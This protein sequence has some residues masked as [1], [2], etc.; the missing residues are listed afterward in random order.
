MLKEARIEN[1][2][3]SKELNWNTLHCNTYAFWFKGN[4]VTHNGIYNR[5][6]WIDFLVKYKRF[7]LS[8]KSFYN[9]YAVLHFPEQIPEK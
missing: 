4:G 2:K 7:N 6:L 3:E 8:C 5:V 9:A 1:S